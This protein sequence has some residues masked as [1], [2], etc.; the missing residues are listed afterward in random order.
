MKTFQLLKSLSNFSYT[1]QRLH[2][3]KFHVGLSNLKLSNSSFFPTALSN[4]TYPQKWCHMTLSQG[5][6]FTWW[7]TYE[8]SLCNFASFAVIFVVLIFKR[9][10]IHG[11]LKLDII[12]CDLSNSFLEARFVKPSGQSGP[13]R[14]FKF[15]FFFK[16]DEFFMKFFEI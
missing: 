1:F 5:S 13:Y 10:F 9:I 8:F 6:E 11:F 3:I 14:W 2:S 16:K 12:L 15:S 7:F 4:Y